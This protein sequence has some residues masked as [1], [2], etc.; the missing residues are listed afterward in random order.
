MPT[1]T[2]IMSGRRR[3]R[4]TVPRGTVSAN[5]GHWQYR[6][7]CDRS[8]QAIAQRRAGDSGQALDVDDPRSPNRRPTQE[9]G[10]R[11][12]GT[13]GDDHPGSKAGR[14]SRNARPRFL[15]RL[16]N[17]RGFFFRLVRPVGERP[18]CSSGEQ[19]ARVAL[20]ERDP[21]ALGVG[22][23]LGWSA[24]SCSRWPPVEQTSR[25][26]TGSAPRAST[27]ECSIPGSRGP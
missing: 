21:G 13:G 8:D 22:P 11:D 14:R 16:S 6:R 19:R 18:H 26:S 9:K 20:V 23:V 27:S 25:T 7:L 2:K 15:N 10:H 5:S 1:V 24:T 12:T 4:H 3:C 17:L